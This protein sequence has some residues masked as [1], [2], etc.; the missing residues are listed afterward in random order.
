MDSVFVRRILGIPHGE[1][2][3]IFSSLQV[4]SL[5]LSLINCGRELAYAIN[6]EALHTLK[7]R[8]CP[9]CVEFLEAVIFQESQ[10][11]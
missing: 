11:I 8:N 5:S 6:W 3:Q 4:L 2:K 10:S 7:L 9:G 1:I